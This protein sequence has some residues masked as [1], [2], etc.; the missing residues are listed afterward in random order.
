MKSTK[1]FSLAIISSVLIL[2]ACNK[3]PDIQNTSTVKMSGEWFAQLYLD[4]EA[5]YPTFQK[6]MTYN[7][8]DPASGQIWV[9]DLHH[10]WIFKAK[11]P[12]DYSTLTFKPADAVD[13]VEDAPK[14]AKIYEGKVL[15]KAARSKSGNV[16][17]SIYLKI[18]F[19]DD[20]G[21]VYEIGGHY[22]TGFFE[23]EY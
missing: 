11:V 19:S 4:G 7:T 22:R 14:T 1:I 21:T 13:N 15:P 2:S 3:K 8:A 20:P 17:D 5:L 12:V 10:L 18:E 9:D 16:V 6:I 23:D